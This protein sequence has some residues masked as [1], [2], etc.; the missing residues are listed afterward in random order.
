MNILKTRWKILAIHRIEKD[1]QSTQLALLDFFG[2]VDSGI[3]VLPC[4]TFNLIFYY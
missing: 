1:Q 2:T 3:S 4:L